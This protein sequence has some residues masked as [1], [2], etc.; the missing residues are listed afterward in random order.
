MNLYMAAEV[1]GL[2]ADAELLALVRSAGCLGAL[3]VNEASYRGKVPLSLQLGELTSVVESSAT[4]TNTAVPVGR[5][6]KFDQSATLNVSLKSWA[7]RGQLLRSVKVCVSHYSDLVEVRDAMVS[8]HAQSITILDQCP[9]QV[10]IPEA[11]GRGCVQLRELTF[12]TCDSPFFGSLPLSTITTIQGAFLAECTSLRRLNL[13]PLSNVTAVG[14]SFLFRCRSLEEVDLSPLSNVRSVGAHFMSG[15]AGVRKL[16]V[17]PL[18]KITS[19]G[20]AFLSACTGLEEVNLD[21]TTA[22]T[23]VEDLFMSGCTSLRRLNLTSLSNVTTVGDSFL[24]NCH[25]L[26]TVDFVGFTKATS[27]G[28]HFMD[29]CVLLPKGPSLNKE[30]KL[31]RLLGRFAPFKM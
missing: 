24:L 29:G 9:K 2:F 28:A 16:D 19:F 17:S 10:F 8:L 5:F 20:T 26:A 31:R 14:G 23:H 3:A 7:H 30:G 13:A 6:A 22:I 25:S 27:V 18:S 15:C 12:A 11:F 1:V 4:A 21:T